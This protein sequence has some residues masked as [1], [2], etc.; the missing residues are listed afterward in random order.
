MIKIC[1]MDL[2]NLPYFA[3]IE[4]L[5]YFNSIEKANLKL[6]SKNWLKLVDSFDQNSLCLYQDFY[7]FNK[8]WPFTLD[9]IKYEEKIKIK[10]SKTELERLEGL[11]FIL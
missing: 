1:K 6:V 8:K 3:Q 2:F 10:C 7:P 4:I 9:K 5:S 11:L